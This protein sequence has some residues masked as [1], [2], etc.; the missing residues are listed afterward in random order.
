MKTLSSWSTHYS[1]PG[2]LSGNSCHDKGMDALAESSD[3]M[4]KQLAKALLEQDEDGQSLKDVWTA[5]RKKELEIEG[6]AP[7][8]G[9]VPLDPGPLDREV[10]ERKV[11]VEQVGDKVLK[12]SFTRFVGRRKTTTEI[13]VRRGELDDLV[14]E[15]AGAAQLLLF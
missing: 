9:P 13:E 2:C 8:S 14:K 10:E 6:H 4:V 15:K 11:E 3:S 12:V 7:A 1:D 5:F